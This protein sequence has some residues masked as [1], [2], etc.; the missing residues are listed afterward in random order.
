MAEYTHYGCWFEEEDPD[1]RM[2]EE[3]DDRN[4]ALA[5]AHSQGVTPVGSNDGETWH[6]I[7]AGVQGDDGDTDA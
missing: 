5:W 2:I 1:K 7:G 4:D 3:A 6:P